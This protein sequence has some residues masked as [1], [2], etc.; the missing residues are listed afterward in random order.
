MSQSFPADF[1]EFVEGNIYRKFLYS[2]VE[3]IILATAF[4][5]KPIYIDHWGHSRLLRIFAGHLQ[6]V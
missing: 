3:T 5:L 1:F 2:A 4:F 6:S